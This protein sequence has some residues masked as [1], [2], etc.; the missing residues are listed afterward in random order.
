MGDKLFLLADM[1]EGLDYGY[2]KHG[3]TPELDRRVIGIASIP[4]NT[5]RTPSLTI[6]GKKEFLD[7]DHIN[8][9]VYGLC[10]T[11]SVLVSRGGGSIEALNIV[12]VPTEVSSARGGPKLNEFSFRASRIRRPPNRNAIFACDQEAGV[13]DA[14]TLAPLASGSV[15]LLAQRLCEEWT[16]QADAYRRAAITDDLK[17]LLVQGTET[18]WSR[19]LL[20]NADRPNDTL[21]VRLPNDQMRLEIAQNVNN[22]TLMLMSEYGKS[23]R[24][25]AVLLDTNGNVIARTEMPGAAISDTELKRIVFLPGFT[26]PNLQMGQKLTLKVWYP[27]EKREEIFH[28][29]TTAAMDAMRKRS[30]PTGL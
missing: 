13:W 12:K 16:S 30:F 9:H 18:G 23:R 17:T 25:Y 11:G 20:W 2:W 22:E 21:K 10:S 6:E 4:I 7:K 5:S 27:R 26:A 24:R 3:Q 29:D 14:Q 1:E 19:L 15:R 28:V 8:A